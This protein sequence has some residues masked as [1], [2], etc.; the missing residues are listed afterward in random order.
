MQD[1]NY[2]T[3][4]SNSRKC[5]SQPPSKN[6][7][8]QHLNH[9]SDQVIHLPFSNLYPT[10]L[11]FTLPR[12]FS[13][14]QRRP[15]STQSGPRQKRR[16]GLSKITTQ[17]TK[18]NQ[19][20]TTTKSRPPGLRWPRRRPRPLVKRAYVSGEQ[21]LPNSLQRSSMLTLVF[22][23]FRHQAKWMGWVRGH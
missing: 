16:Q 19:Q 3:C 11:A 5:S 8:P 23:Q 17:P 4:F 22:L 20:N 21:I 6:A 1:T 18:P 9:H 12:P 15:L 2:S 14:H 7:L 10:S 13:S